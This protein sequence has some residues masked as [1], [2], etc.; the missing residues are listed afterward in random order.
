M[1]WEYTPY[2][3]PL[4]GTAAVTVILAAY[5]WRRRRMPGARPFVFITAAV[6]AWSLGYALELGSASLAAKLF[7]SNFNFLAVPIVPAAWLV[8]VLEYTGRGKRLTRRDLALL[9]VEPLA[10]SLLAWTNEAHHLFRL[11]PSLVL[12]GDGQC[13]ALNPDYGIGFWLHGVYSYALLLYGTLLLAQDFFRQP[14]FHR[15]QTG[16]MLIGALIPWVANALYLS[17]LTPFPQLDLT[18]F[19]FGL[20]SVA[21]AWGLFYYRL[22][23]VVP[24]AR[25]V[26]IEE[27]DDGII[28]LDVQDRILDLNPAAR[29]LLDLSDMEALGQ[30]IA[31]AISQW[32]HPDE[33][34]AEHTRIH[35]EITLHT[36][37]TAHVFDLRISHLCDR[38]GRMTGKIAVLR[39]ITE[40]K[41]AT[42]ALRQSEQRFRA[43]AQNFRDG[44][45]IFD[46]DIN[47]V[48]YANPS[49]ATILDLPLTDILAPDAGALFGRMV[50]KED[51]P[52]VQ[53]VS[54]C[55][56]EARREGQTQ[57]INVEFRIRQANGALRWIHQCSYPVMDQGK[58]FNQIHM[59]LS[60]ITQ[61]KES[62][63]EREKLIEE[64]D[65]FAATVAHDLK[66]PLTFVIGMAE[67]L[68]DEFD[69]IPSAE[70]LEYLR[71]IIQHGHRMN[72]IVDGLLALA[73]IHKAKVGLHPL[74]MN[75]LATEA[76][77]QLAPLIEAS[78]TEIILPDTWPVA[79]GYG[80]WIEEVW[81]N[82]LSNAIKYGG[83]P[84]R[85]E[86]GADPPEGEMVRFWVRDNGPGLTPTQQECLFTPSTRIDH[87]GSPG[88]G[89]G[90]S[91][92]RRIVERLG[93][94]VAV[95]SE[96]RPGQGSLFSFTLPAYRPDTHDAP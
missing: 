68:A 21:V 56:A 37:D 82:Y 53:E 23:D 73:R 95:E 48:I 51:L 1:T 87:T 4:F 55:A 10:V 32:P 46:R 41:Q 43:L 18:P 81:V 59:I 80:P 70:A 66:S 58:P 54:R 93:G 75:L 38:Q 44:L 88:H 45:L 61:R 62:E 14:G 94:Q 11:N 28:V 64:L 91:I 83:R 34:P 12:L 84:A 63:K 16:P 86:L 39:D 6:S 33:E 22:L 52:R 79:V 25:D 35:A 8:F 27:M 92:V 57:P 85:V 3:L 5:G 72:R 30:P 17:G 60:D 29:Q 49:A 20:S 13:L 69:N 76:R 40:R 89:L 26:L 78:Q 65:A 24:V 96:G 50:F 90:L 67:M 36:H 19:A 15:K 42:A 2:A 7:W 47:Q 77:L 9:A 74:D 31:Q 71:D